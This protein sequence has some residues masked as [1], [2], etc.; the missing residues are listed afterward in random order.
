MA[1]SDA[2]AVKSVSSSTHFAVSTGSETFHSII[3]ASTGLSATPDR[4]SSE[5]ESDG[6]D[7]SDEM[8]LGM[9]LGPVGLPS[10]PLTSTILAEHEPGFGNE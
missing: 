8:R 5:D 4:R 1:G 3:V 9:R 7:V 2:L 6:S 10:P